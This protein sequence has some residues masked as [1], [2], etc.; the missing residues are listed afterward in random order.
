MLFRDQPLWQ[1]QLELLSKLQPERIFISARTDPSWRPVD[2][3]FV[4]DAQPSRG[5]LSGI[6]AALSRTK[7]DHLLVLGIDM[8]FL[9]VDYLTELVARIRPGCGA[10]PTIAGRAEPLA[11][12]Y[13]RNADVDLGRALSGDNFSLRPLIAELIF[14]RKLKVVE[15]R[16]DERSLFRNLN[17]P[18]DVIVE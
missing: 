4:A 5:P 15:V 8:P 2:I 14:A 16:Q 3:E 7:S 17:E 10:V 18:G 13:P 12:I 1:R 9:T 6:A 11:A